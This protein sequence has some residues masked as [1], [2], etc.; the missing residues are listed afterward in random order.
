MS[1]SKVRPMHAAVASSRP[2]DGDKRFRRLPMT[3]RT[4]VGIFSSICTSLLVEPTGSA[5][6]PS[7]NRRSVSSRNSGWPSVRA[8]MALAKLALAAPPLAAAMNSSVSRPLRPASS[9][10]WKTGD[11]DSSPSVS[12]NG[13]WRDSSVSR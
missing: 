12:N 11:R 6:R 10:R 1:S 2:A 13:C 4:P 8:W 5:T 9:M 7:I 3:S